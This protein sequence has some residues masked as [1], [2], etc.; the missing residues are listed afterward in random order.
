MHWF[1]TIATRKAEKHFFNRLKTT[2]S[3]LWKKIF[4]QTMER[5]WSNKNFSSRF[6]HSQVMFYSVCW[7]F[8]F[9]GRNMFGTDC[10]PKNCNSF[11]SESQKK[12][13][14]VEEILKPN[15]PENEQTTILN[16]K[17]IHPHLH[18]SE[19]IQ[20][21]QFCAHRIVTDQWYTLFHA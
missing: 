19:K 17:W 15:D 18:L 9:L 1:A 5:Q 2:V 7:S 8:V 13:S 6:Q 16:K 11:N 10:G 14:F 4:H 20:H 21:R 3:N 12:F